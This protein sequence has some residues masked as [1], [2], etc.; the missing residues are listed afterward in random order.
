MHQIR[1]TSSMSSD[2][3]ARLA[4]GIQAAE[5]TLVCDDGHKS[6]Y[7][8]SDMVYFTGISG[9]VSYHNVTKVNKRRSRKV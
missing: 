4:K 9:T 3:L 5:V 1:I 8:T 6:T 7:K 2:E